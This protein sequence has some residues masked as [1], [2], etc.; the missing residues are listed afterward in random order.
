MKKAYALEKMR[1]THILLLSLLLFS[2]Y[3]FYTDE[4]T[5][6]RSVCEI[7]S[8]VSV[9][10][11]GTPLPNGVYDPRLGPASSQENT[12][13]PCP[14]CAMPYLHCPGHFGHVELCVPLY[15][16]L[17]FGK[18]VETLR[19]KCWACHKFKASPRDC[20]AWQIK[21]QLLQQNR[22]REALDLEDNLVAIAK[23]K[24]ATASNSHKEEGGNNSH[25]TNS[26]AASEQAVQDL[27]NRIQQ[28]L[29]T[30]TTT[31]TTQS[32]H[33]LSSVEEDLY[34]Q[35][36]KEVVTSCKATKSCPN[37]GAF[38]PRIRQDASNKIFQAP[39]A[40]TSARINEAEGIEILPALTN[41]VNSMAKED[42]DGAPATDADEEEED[43][44]STSRDKYMHPS[45]IQA[46]LNKTW[47]HHAALLEQILA[48]QGP[49]IFFVQAVPV[50][51][52]RFRPPMHLG[53]MVV[54]HAQNMYLNQIMTQN[55]LVRANF[56]ANQESK[57]HQNWIQLQTLY[58]CYL[59]S[60]KD[61]SAA[62]ASQISPGIRQLLERKE[63][64]F[65][66]HMMGKR[67]NFACRSVISPDPYIGT[68]E[69]GIPRYFAETLTYPTPVTDITIAHLKTLVERG[70]HQW[71][72]ARWVEFPDG[73]KIELS[74]M[75][76][77]QRQAIASRLLMH[78]RK[79]GGGKPAI[80][81]RQM[82]DGDMVLMNRQVREFNVVL[83][84]EA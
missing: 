75:D 6:N 70:P 28:S 80:V 84:V 74:K 61:P 67:V 72:G 11:L 77:H 15:H 5:R 71:P 69:I 68:N 56:V 22:Y 26:I 27:L 2:G 34:R 41:D 18:L 37:C 42:K 9:D 52:N 23:E 65:R 82:Q 19:M 66:K 32:K 39:L 48:V 30:T 78:A 60:S 20:K 16:P 54:E 40:Q 64:I 62:A 31:A 29:T 55:E 81:G 45:E 21:F 53:G 12:G 3:S 73:R 24:A 25:K 59:D 49:S 36:V 1:S 10:A 44:P 47:K 13:L 83:C 50:P 63:G 43:A 79:G 7:T 14:T 38:S 4:D 35:W 17:L 57:A 76:E 46:Q 51:P 33:K 8:S 58:N